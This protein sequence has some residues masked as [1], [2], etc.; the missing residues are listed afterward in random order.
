MT[1]DTK[2]LKCERIHWSLE[3]WYFCT[4]ASIDDENLDACALKGS[5]KSNHAGDDL[6]ACVLK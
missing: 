3:E 5:V 2:E 6:M 1:P 4:R